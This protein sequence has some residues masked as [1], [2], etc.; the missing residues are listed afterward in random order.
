MAEPDKQTFEVVFSGN[1]G[2]RAFDVD[3]VEHNLF[4]R[5]KRVQIKANGPDVLLLSS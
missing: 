2:L 5:D 4:A 3:V 1:A